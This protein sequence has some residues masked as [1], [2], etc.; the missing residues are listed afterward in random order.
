MLF[1][2]KPKI[3]EINLVGLEVL[4]KTRLKIFNFT[5][6]KIQVNVHVIKGDFLRA[7]GNFFNKIQKNA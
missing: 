3:K 5:A 6:S 4:E 7:I 2:Q 1:I